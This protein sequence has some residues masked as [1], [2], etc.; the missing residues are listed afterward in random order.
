MGS[1]L[2][3]RLYYHI[4]FAFRS[5][6]QDSLVVV[7]VVLRPGNPWDPFVGIKRQD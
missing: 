2:A 7:V 6:S 4:P 5:V 1:C 3:R